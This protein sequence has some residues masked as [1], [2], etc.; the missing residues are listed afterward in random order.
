MNDLSTDFL[1]DL[2]EIV[3][4]VREEVDE[5]ERRHGGPHVHNTINDFIAY[6]TA[7]TGRAVDG[8]FRNIREGYN[9]TTQREMLVKAAGL[10]V[11]AAM[12][13]RR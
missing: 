12:E 6:A 13:A 10:L 1:N 5:A 3:S 9:E 8:C 4:A 11:R 2:D 7:Y